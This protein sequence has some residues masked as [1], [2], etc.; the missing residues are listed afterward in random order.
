MTRRGQAATGIGRN[1][2]RSD[3][4]VGRQVGGTQGGR[5]RWI[6]LA[7]CTMSLLLVS[8][9]VTIVNVALPTIAEELHATLQTLQWTIGAYALVIASFLLVSGTLADRFGRKRVFVIGTSIFITGSLL[10]GF[11]PTD[12]WLIAFRMV[13]A[14]GGSMMTPVALAIVTNIFTVPKERARAIGWW[15]AASGIGLAAGP[16]LGG[17][18]VDSLGWRSIFFVNVPIG[19]VLIALTLIFVPESKADVPRKFDPA[20]QILF[21]AGL[22][23]LT[24]AIIEAP[25]LG[26]G[27]PVIV[28]CFAVA[29]AGI[30]ALVLVERRRA[31]PAVPVRLFEHAPFAKAFATAMLSFFVLIGLLFANTFYLQTVEDLTPSQAGIMTLPLALAAVVASLLSGRLVSAGHTRAT[32]LVAGSLVALGSLLLLLVTRGLP[33][34]LVVVP[35]AVFGFGYGMLNDPVSVTAISQLPNAQ[36]GVA[37]SMVSVARQLGQVLGVAVVGSLLSAQLGDDLATGFAE[38]SL[39]VWILLAACGLAIVLLNLRAG[40]VPTVAG[41][42]SRVRTADA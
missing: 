40:A 13:Q 6:A 19:L 24:F 20:G 12:L 15:A 10:C 9:D 31:Q 28:A 8:I 2:G 41:G 18:L 32:L 16:L 25:N 21:V 7:V 34:G 4:T 23:P 1:A 42:S 37:A 36:A 17:F 11:A 29:A 22:L 14:V 33:V 30:A 26:W 39:P 5:R 3:P 27:S 38:A 35:Y